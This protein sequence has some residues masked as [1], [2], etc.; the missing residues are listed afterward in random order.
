MPYPDNFSTAAFDRHEGRIN[1]TREAAYQYAKAARAAL[2]D[3]YIKLCSLEPP[4]DWPGLANAVHDA[5]DAIERAI[6]EIGAQE[7]EWDA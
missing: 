5:A 7:P 1:D 4:R 2:N 6:G 3:C